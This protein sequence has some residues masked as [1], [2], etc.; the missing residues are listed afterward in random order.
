MTS[1]RAVQNRLTRFQ[2]RRH[3]ATGKQTDQ[4]ND[5]EYEEQ[6]LRDSGRS[7]RHAAKSKESGDQRNDQK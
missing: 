4:K 5:E 2:L 3:A 6:D 7:T 1:G